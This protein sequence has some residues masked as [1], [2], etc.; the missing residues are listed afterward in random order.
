MSVVCAACITLCVVLPLYVH[1][2]PSGYKYDDSILM[3]RKTCLNEGK[4]NGEA[5]NYET[6]K[7]ECPSYAPVYDATNKVCIPKCSADEVYND[8]KKACVPYV[9]SCAPAP[10]VDTS[11]NIY[12]AEHYPR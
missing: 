7:C 5:Y 12:Y 4:E 6:H 1:P 9:P 3:C 2:C 11:G 8:A 10:Y